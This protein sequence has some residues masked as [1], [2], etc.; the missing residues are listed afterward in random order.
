MLK[1][2]ITLSALKEERGG[3]GLGCSHVGTCVFVCRSCDSDLT[4]PISLL[5]SMH[6]VSRFSPPLSGR[7]G[8]KIKS[9]IIS[10]F[11]SYLEGKKKLL[12]L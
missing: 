8:F 12:T 7:K 1:I 3:V 4:W 9:T 5:Y 10:F 2:R 11:S 6:F